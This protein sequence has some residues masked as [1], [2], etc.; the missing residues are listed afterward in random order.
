MKKKSNNFLKRE[1]EKFKDAK[2]LE[3]LTF[4]QLKKISEEE[5]YIN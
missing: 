1:I 2:Y 3:D 5:Y 4:E